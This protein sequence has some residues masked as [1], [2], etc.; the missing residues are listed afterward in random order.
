MCH[1]KYLLFKKNMLDF[2]LNKQDRWEQ[3]D[4][5]VQIW[6]ENKQLNWLKKRTQR[7]ISEVLFMMSWFI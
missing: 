6:L 4:I 1:E 2:Y 7:N 3:M 5:L